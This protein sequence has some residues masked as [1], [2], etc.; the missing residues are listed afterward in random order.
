M[1]FGRGRQPNQSLNNTIDFY[2]QIAEN[3]TSAPT[4]PDG[5]QPY[6]FSKGKE[7]VDSPIF[8]Y[9][10]SDTLD[11]LYAQFKSVLTTNRA[12]SD[13]VAAFW[14]NAFGAD[15][16]NSQTGNFDLRDVYGTG[17]GD[18]FRWGMLEDGIAMQ[19][20][21]QVSLHSVM[22]GVP[23]VYYGEE[24][25]FSVI[26][27]SG[28]KDYI[29]LPQDELVNATA[30]GF[31]AYISNRTLNGCQDDSV[32]LDHFDYSH[33]QF[34]FTSYV[35]W[36]RRTYSA[37]TNGVNVLALSRTNSSEFPNT[38]DNNTVTLT[39]IGKGYDSYQLAGTAVG[40][41]TIPDPA[42]RMWFMFS[43]HNETATFTGN[44]A[45][46][47]GIVSMF[48][49]NTQVRNI[50]PPFDT[51]TV[52]MANA[53]NEYGCMETLTASA[54]WW[55]GAYVA[56]ADWVQPPP[57]VVRFLPGH[58]ARVAFTGTDSS[59]AQAVDISF[60]FSDAM[61]CASVTAA[62]TVS[63]SP[64]PAGTVDATTVE[65]GAIDAYYADDYVGTRAGTWMWKAT[66]NGA[67][68]IH[69]ITIGVNATSSG[70]LGL[71]FSPTFL[72][73]LGRANNPMVFGKL[74]LYDSGLI[75][76]V[77][78]AVSLV[79]SAVGADKFRVSYDHG[80]NFTAWA[81]YTSVSA[82]NTAAAAASGTV[83]V[84]Y[85]SSTVLSAAHVS[86][87]SFDS[88][89]HAVGESSAA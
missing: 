52:P 10:L 77:G 22:T 9:L 60:V 24:Q 83:L 35:L 28:T 45:N 20:I 84:Q 50:Y 74:G 37:L 85:W 26:D 72:L 17:N 51:F 11:P 67:E 63:S 76:T 78:G 30:F 61:S 80:L 42:F 12:T 31:P 69:R 81:A 68:G 14:R 47:T 59:A 75:G 82:V 1:F 62:V 56:E 65:C 7:M 55:F 38:F 89:Y 27:G 6:I 54:P 44:C 64:G 86:W 16:I 39:S 48:P 66:L 57:V 79:H 70:G 41:Y 88:S 25:M 73:R 46:G 43:G 3:Y 5:P 4:G 19:R 2:A 8:N 58:D 13:L 29:Y 53:T 18:V 34:V 23:T 33:P 21:G 36:T 71:Q 15:V 32:S 49:V 87:C 40:N